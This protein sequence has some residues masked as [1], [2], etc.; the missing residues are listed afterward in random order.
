MT[1]MNMTG[2]NTTHCGAPRAEVLGEDVSLST[3]TTSI[4]LLRNAADQRTI[5]LGIDSRRISNSISPWS[6][7]SKTLARSTKTVAVRCCG[8]GSPEVQQLVEGG[9]VGP[10]TRS[11]RNQLGLDDASDARG[12]NTLHEPAKAAGQRDRSVGVAVGCR[13][14]RIEKEYDDSTSPIPRDG[15]CM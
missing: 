3:Q 5:L 2:P 6:T 12:R 11:L 14:L 10:I 13:F 1:M 4:V 7:L 15:S 9:I 8:A